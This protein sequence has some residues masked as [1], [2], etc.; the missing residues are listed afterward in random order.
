MKLIKIGSAALNQTPLDWENN[1]KNI[2]EAIHSAKAQGVSVLCLPELCISGYGCEDAFHSPS[3]QTTAQECLSELLPDTKGIIVALGLPLLYHNG[4]FNTVCLVADGTIRG[5]VAKKFLAGDGIHYEPRWFKPWQRGKRGVVEVLGKEYPIGD[6]YFNC[7]GIKLGFEICEEAWVAERPGG[8]LAL[9]GVDFILNPSAS[10]FAFGKDDVR[11]RF[12]LEGSRAFGVSY[13]YCDLLGNESGRAIYDGANIIASAG[14]LLAVGPRLTFS[15]WTV[16]AAVVDVEATRMSQSRTGSFEPSFDSVVEG[17]VAFPFT[18]P[19][20][21]PIV[22]AASTPTWEKSPH[23]KEEEFTRAVALGLFDYLRKSRS[24]G[25]V[26]S[27]SGGADSCSIA[28]LIY[29]MVKLGVSELGKSAFLERLGL[30][31]LESKCRADADIVKNLL[32]CIYQSTENSGPIT[33]NAARE[34]ALA[35]GAD[36]LELDVNDLFKGYVSRVSQALHREIRWDADDI[37]LQNIQARVRSPGAWLIANLKHFLL[38]ST[39]NRSEVAVGYATMDGDTS[40]GL[41][42]LGGIDK[43]FLREWLRWVEKTGP[44][45][46]GPLPQ[47]NAVNVQ[48]PTAE[49]RPVGFKQTDEADLMPYDLLDAIERSAIR[50]KRS[51]LEVFQCLQPQFS[52]ISP[53]QLALWVDRFFR[54]WCQNQWKRERYAPSF[55]VDDENLDP[56]TWCRFPILSGGYERELKELKKYVESL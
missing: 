38:V 4:L 32:T 40:G 22:N 35:V 30:S 53:N 15:P 41:S 42:P 1:L 34:V 6:Y 46:L 44:R 39:S 54:L 19:S 31:D 8:D 55:H 27:L 52:E 10:H 5:F 21:H 28:C 13:L 18:F 14:K 48:A 29:F 37:A 7:G 24:K 47:V 2:R 33:Q 11:L 25:F 16:T 50:D 23:H 9:C 56:R 17:S 45:G 3:V 12:V 51:P 49:L 43:A 26:V 20:L 36:F